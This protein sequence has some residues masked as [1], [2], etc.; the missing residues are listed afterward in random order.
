MRMCQG[1]T[2]TAETTP[3]TSFSLIQL[4]TE[5]TFHEKTTPELTVHLNLAVDLTSIINILLR[6]SISTITPTAN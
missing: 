1:S 2:V 3:I 5:L 4:Y 6:C